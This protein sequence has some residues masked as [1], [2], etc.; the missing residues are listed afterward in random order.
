MIKSMRLLRLAI[1]LLLIS[2][3]TGASEYEFG[4]KVLAQDSDI[5]RALYVRSS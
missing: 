1:A 2:G 5:G 4:T 3:L